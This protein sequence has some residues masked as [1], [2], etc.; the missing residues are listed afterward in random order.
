[1]PAT[2]QKELGWRI[3]PPVSEPRA[4]KHS[5][6]ATAAQEPPEEP[7]GAYSVFQGFLVMPNAEVSVVLPMANSSIL[8]FPRITAPARLS[9]STA[10]AV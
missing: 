10:S 6:D 9:P 2:P 3:E 7:P 4:Q 5:S 8:V 1:M